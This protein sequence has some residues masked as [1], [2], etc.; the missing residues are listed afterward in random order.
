MIK[1]P[2]YTYTGQLRLTVFLGFIK[3][4]G[5]DSINSVGPVASVNSFDILITREIGY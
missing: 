5:Y 3:W 4:S 1:R 2:I